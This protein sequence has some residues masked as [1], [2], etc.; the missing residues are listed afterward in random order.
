MK[1]R[2]I[3]LLS[4]IVCL[5]VLPAVFC[6]E[7]AAQQNNAEQEYINKV[8]SYMYSQ[9]ADTSADN[10]SADTKKRK[11]NVDVWA[12]IRI[13]V[14]LA[15]MVG[16]IYAIFL[17]MKK[18]LKVKED[19]GDGVQ[20]LTSRTLGPGKQV[21]VVFV[22]GRYLILGVTNDNINLLGE[23]TDPKEIEHIELYANEQAAESGQ[24]FGQMISSMYNRLFGK[25]TADDKKF[26][27]EKD[28]MD[29][30]RR[31][32]EKLGRTDDDAA[33]TDMEVGDENE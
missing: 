9:N 10:H 4:V 25:K 26:D 29:F 27:Y 28:E 5:S 31:Q 15:L 6:Q 16:A 8:R 12:Y 21:Q 30:I 19:T 7:T 11:T 17:V 33:D 22:H 18:F 2:I 13:I 14:V 20:L 1:N 23:I 32:K 3:L 24:T